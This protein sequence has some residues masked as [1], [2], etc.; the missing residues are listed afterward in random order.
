MGDSPEAIRLDK[1]LWQARF[2][3]SRAIAQR[4]VEGGAVR[5][6]TVRVQKPATNVRVGDGVTIAY[7][8]RVHA[9]RIVGLGGRRGPAS[10]AQTLY[11]EVGALAAPLEPGPEPDT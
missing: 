5:V 9:V 8:G 10:E 2:C 7:A 4:L 3:K 6:N 1:W 11:I